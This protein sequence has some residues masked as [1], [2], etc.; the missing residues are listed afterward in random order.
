MS[1]ELAA[2]A[3]RVGMAMSRSMDL[4]ELCYEHDHNSDEVREWLTEDRNRLMRA[5]GVGPETLGQYAALCRAQYQRVKKWCEEQPEPE[6]FSEDRCETAAR[7]LVGGAIWSTVCGRLEAWAKE[8]EFAA[9]AEPGNPLQPED[10]PSGDGTGAS[11]PGTVQEPDE[12][13]GDAADLPPASD[14]LPATADESG[15]FAE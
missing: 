3:E 13:T 6:G 8:D 15:P 4:C 10:G 9:V 1:P 2:K 14:P 12:P 5:E 11:L 7:Q